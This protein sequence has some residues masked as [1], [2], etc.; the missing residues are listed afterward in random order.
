[1]LL[2]AV[3]GP[4]GSGK[5]SG[6]ASFAGAAAQLGLV[7]G[8]VAL[9][10]ER[11]EPDRGAAD[12]A[13]HMLADGRLLPLATRQPIGYTIDTATVQEL[14]A[15]VANLRPGIDVL[16]LDEFGRWE[17]EGQGHWHLWDFVLAAKPK[18]LVI[19][20]KQSA[21][22]QIEGRMGRRFDHILSAQDGNVVDALLD[23]AAQR[24]DWERVGK[25]GAGAGAL[26][27]TVGAALHT[28]KFPLTGMAMSSAQAAVLTV[29][30]DGLLHRTRVVWVSFI[31]SGLKA[32]SPSGKRVGP[33][34][35][36]A[37]QGLLFTL[38]TALAGWNAVGVFVG[39]A[40]MGAWASSQG[41][42]VQY[43]ML[44]GAL[45]K[46]YDQV[47]KWVAARTDLHL[48]ALLALV[49]IAAAL[50][51]TLAGFVAL[52][53]WRRRAKWRDRLEDWMAKPRAPLEMRRRKGLLMFSLFV[54]TALV[55]G[56]LLSTGTKWADVAV[57][58]G[59]AV[60]VAFLLFAVIQRWNPSKLIGYLRRKGKWGP[61]YALAAALEAKQERSS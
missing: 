57:L 56:I 31:A 30:G 8:F 21:L 15:W 24:P 53:F 34:V 51:A 52:T 12:Y 11:D 3:T 61:A 42:I 26:E 4:I 59:R 35:A 18:L 49:A 43:L 14:S 36:I 29:A 9:A 39:G 20:V 17:A 38:S 13:L 32:L 16:I 58:T 25:F 22:V 60:G 28:V 1:M 50:N 54:P 33:M 46:A 40:L 37:M 41:F 19:G 23:I 44:G 6:L 47:V 48:P 2:L 10:G 45:E 7:D 27:M 5:S 55:G